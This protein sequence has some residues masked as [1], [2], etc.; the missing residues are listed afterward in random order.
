VNDWTYSVVF[1]KSITLEKLVDAAPRVLPEL[2]SR[3]SMVVKDH[4]KDG[5]ISAFDSNGEER[6]FESV[7]AA[8]SGLA[9]SGGGLICLVHG[10]ESLNL[11]FRV[12]PPTLYL[13]SGGSLFDGDIRL[14][15]EMRFGFYWM[16]EHLHPIFGSS[17]DLLAVENLWFQFGIFGW[18]GLRAVGDLEQEDI[19]NGRSPD[20]LPWL[21]YFDTTHFPDVRDTLSGVSAVRLEPIGQ[22]GMM[23]KFATYPWEPRFALRTAEGYEVV[24]QFARSVRDGK[25]LSPSDLGR[26]RRAIHKHK[27]NPAS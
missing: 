16:C 21:A 10:Q 5:L 1:D 27:E 26:V 13:S 17:E 25:R 14:E 12:S 6:F 4:Q 8:T 7:A 22:T 23:V 24:D 9:L 3:G 11:G 18:D 2:L 19:Q 20:V 15:S